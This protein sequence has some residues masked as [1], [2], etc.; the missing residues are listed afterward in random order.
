MVA[1]CRTEWRSQRGIG[2]ASWMTVPPFNCCSESGAL[3]SEG[4]S[5]FK[6][7]VRDQAGQLRK[8]GNLTCV[9]AEAR[10]VLQ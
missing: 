3:Q 9:G 8:G 7:T 5:S 1:R 2:A 4:L 6:A 10:G